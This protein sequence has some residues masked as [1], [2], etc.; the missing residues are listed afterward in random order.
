MFERSSRKATPRAAKGLNYKYPHQGSFDSLQ[1]SS[2]DPTSVLTTD[3][4]NII[5]GNYARDGD[6]AT[7]AEGIK[8]MAD[9]RKL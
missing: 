1:N 2:I 7:G 9:F 8:D 4:T 3:N 6:L 5:E